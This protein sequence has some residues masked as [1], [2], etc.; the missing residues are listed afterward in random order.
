[1]NCAQIRERL[2]DYLYDELPPESRGA[3]A[4]HLQG[5]PTC[6]AE[7]ASYAQTLGS[8]RAALAGPLAQEP[9]AR[10]HLAVIEAAKAAA[11]REAAPK[12]K[13]SAPSEELGFLARLWRTP[14]F[15][16][17]FGAASVATVVFLVRVIKNPEVLPGQRPHSI[18]ERALATPEPVPPPEP[19]AAAPQAAAISPAVQAKASDHL[20]AAK[21]SASAGSATRHAANEAS[22]RVESPPPVIKNKKSISDDPLSGLSFGEGR[23]SAG[24]PSRFAEPP[25]P[26]EEQRRGGKSIDNLMGSIEKGSNPNPTRARTADLDKVAQPSTRDD[27]LLS[28]RK[29]VATAAPAKKAPA[30]SPSAEMDDSLYRPSGL[31]GQSVPAVPAY[32]PATPKPTNTARSASPAGAPAPVSP[33]PTPKHEMLK[34]SESL[35]EAAVVSDE[36]SCG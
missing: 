24:A 26:R 29:S 36:G 20:V 34:M 32:A 3:F 14:W 33:R 22:A 4:E 1:M 30:P 21:P 6:K 5:C 11:N 18:E 31:A 9:P 19:A 2:V 13:V 25:P 17:A 27:E 28:E 15:L 12:A 16:P 35:P 8:A 7:V 23:S 10:V